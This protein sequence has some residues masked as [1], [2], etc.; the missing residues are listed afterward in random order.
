VIEFRLNAFFEQQGHFYHH[1]ASP[2][3]LCL[4]QANDPEPIDLGMDDF[5]KRTTGGRIGEHYGAQSRPIDGSIG[6]YDSI[7]EPTD[8]RRQSRRVTGDRLTGQQIGVD[9]EGAPPL[10]HGADRTL[11]GT[12]RPG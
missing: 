8:H 6:G 2:F 12:E 9:P 7:T 11:S 4:I 10:E 1:D 5:F 3:A